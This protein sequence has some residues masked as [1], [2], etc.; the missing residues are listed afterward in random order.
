MRLYIARVSTKDNTTEIRTIIGSA[1]TKRVLFFNAYDKST[2]TGSMTVPVTS[3]RRSFAPTPYIIR[4]AMMP[5]A[6]TGRM[7]ARDMIK[8]RERSSLFFSMVYLPD[9]RSVRNIN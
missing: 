4:H 7:A 6:S 2:D 5:V 8:E 9:S 1:F 3:T